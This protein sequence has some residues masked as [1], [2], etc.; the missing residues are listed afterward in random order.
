MRDETAGNGDYGS[1]ARWRRNA[2][3]EKKERQKRER[4]RE[5]KGILNKLH[6]ERDRET[7]ICNLFKFPLFSFSLSFYT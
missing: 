2:N 4:E 1:F 7:Y 6:R 3:M 5:S